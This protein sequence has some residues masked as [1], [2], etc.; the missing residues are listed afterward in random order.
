MGKE[1][2]WEGKEHKVKVEE[3]EGSRKEKGRMKDVEK[4]YGL[5]RH[6]GMGKKELIEEQKKGSNKK[7]LNF[8]IFSQQVKIKP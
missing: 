1:N 6:A 3:G 7:I 5:W 2:K 4:S 8:G